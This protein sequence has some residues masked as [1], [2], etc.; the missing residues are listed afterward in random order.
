VLAEVAK[1]LVGISGH[2]V[3]LHAPRLPEEE[4]GAPFLALREGV[5]LAACETVDRCVGKDQGKLK[6]RD[7]FP[8]VIE[9]DGSTLSD[10]REDLTEKLSVFVHG[11]ETS[12]HFVANVRIVAREG[13]T[14]HLDPLCGWDEGLR[15]EQVR[16]VG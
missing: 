16:L 11:V 15:D 3:T 9:V 1:H 6:L 7:R 13:E 2:A 12:Q 8:E 4:Q 5:A 14:G 10:V